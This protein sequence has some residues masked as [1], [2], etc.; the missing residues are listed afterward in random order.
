MKIILK[1][2]NIYIS[3]KYCFVNFNLYLY[4]YKKLILKEI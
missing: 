4:I 1:N 3:N 2:Q